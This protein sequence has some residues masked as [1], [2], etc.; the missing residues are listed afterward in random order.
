[1]TMMK[2]MMVGRKKLEKGKALEQKMIRLSGDTIAKIE[3]KIGK[4][5]FSAWVRAVI[6]KEIKKG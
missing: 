6:E 3:A 2:T 1:M 4:R 5:G